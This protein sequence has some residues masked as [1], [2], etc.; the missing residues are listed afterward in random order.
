MPFVMV[1]VPE[2]QVFDVMQFIVKS[3]RRANLEPWDQAAVDE[4]FLA[5][6]E[7]IRSLL[8]TVAR[9]TLAGRE[10]GT[11]TVIKAMELQLRDLGGIL[12]LVEQGCQDMSRLPLYEVRTDTE[13]GPS[14]RP[15]PVRKF[16]MDEAVAR[17]VRSAE[18]T[19]RELEPHP[20]DGMGV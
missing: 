5:A 13:V 3:A 20:L 18:Q 10:V 16:V 12:K 6:D 9:S 14:G 1:P 15:R 11:D 8:S 4:F 17:M 2:E 7:P 19:A